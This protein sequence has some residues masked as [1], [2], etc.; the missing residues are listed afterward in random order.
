M[1]RCATQICLSHVTHMF[2][3]CHTQNNESCHTYLS[4]VTQNIEGQITT[5]IDSMCEM[6]HWYV[7]HYSTMCVTWRIHTRLWRYM[8]ASCRTYACRTYACIMLLIRISHVTHMNAS[9]HTYKWV[10]SHI[11]MRHDKYTKASW[12]TYEFVISHV[13]TRHVTRT[14]ASCHTYECV[15]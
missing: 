14:N 10:M 3:P 8:N 15:M 12:H 5:G 2:E 7:W 13:R 9:R 1:Q 4:H 11:W 6:T